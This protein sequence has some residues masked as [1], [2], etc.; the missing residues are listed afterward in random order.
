[1]YHGYTES[2]EKIAERKARILAGYVP[3]KEETK[4]EGEQPSSGGA[5]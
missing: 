5:E 1:M 4:E 2:E 3:P